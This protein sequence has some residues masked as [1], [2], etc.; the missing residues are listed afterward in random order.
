MDDSAVAWT[1]PGVLGLIGVSLLVVA[2]IVVAGWALK[3]GNEK[4][5]CDCNAEAVSV[6]C[7]YQCYTSPK[8]TCDDLDDM[9]AVR[10]NINA[11]VDK[12]KTEGPGSA[13]N[14]TGAGQRDWVSGGKIAGLTDKGEVW[15]AESVYEKHCQDVV[16]SIYRHEVVHAGDDTC[17]NPWTFLT[18][19][20]GGMGDSNYAQ[21]LHDRSEF[22]AYGTQNSYL[23]DRIAALEVTC[24]AQYR[25][26]WSGEMF[27]D[28]FDCIGAC[29]CSLTHPCA[30]LPPCIQLNRETGEATG[31]R[32]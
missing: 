29:G 9:K 20:V 11:F 24:N 13:G 25:C 2:I 15:I 31:L 1:L 8:C 21:K 30:G 32:F 17:R 6:Q 27:D 3:C 12:K 26:S 14:D 7:N 28:R 22:A 10:D 19:T 23:N 18:G 16:E 5:L 4:T